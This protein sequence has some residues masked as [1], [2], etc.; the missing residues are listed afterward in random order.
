MGKL[1]LTVLSCVLLFV[2]AIA[3][4]ATGNFLMGWVAAIWG[5]AL[6]AVYLRARAHGGGE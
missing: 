3:S 5:V 6:P 2:A 4:F 1:R